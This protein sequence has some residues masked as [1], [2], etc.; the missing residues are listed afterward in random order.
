MFIHLTT[1]DSNGGVIF[2][3]TYMTTTSLSIHLLTDIKVASMS[4]L[5]VNSA[6]IGGYMSFSVM[7]FSGYVPSSG[8][9]GSCGGFIPGFLRNLQT[10]SQSCCCCSVSQLCLTLWPHG[11]Q[12]A[13]SPCS[14]PSPEVCPSS[15]PLHWWCHPAISSSNALFSFC[16]Q[17]FP[18]L[19]TGTPVSL[20]LGFQWVGC[21]HGMSK[22]LELQIHI[23][24]SNE[25]SGNI[26]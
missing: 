7:V 16:P 10:V 19:G 2:H 17:S 23:S 6:A 13:R 22:I 21:S 4:W 8:V 12:Q 5:F 24:P 26:I 18:A 25:Y 15:C 20:A 11:L 1:T 14:S 9:V 3:C